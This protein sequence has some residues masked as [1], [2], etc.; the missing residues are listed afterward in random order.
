MALG[1]TFS[2][3]QG[4]VFIIC[5]QLIELHN[6]T[7]SVRT[8]N[9]WGI[10]QECLFPPVQPPPCWERWIGCYLSSYSSEI[11]P[12]RT[13]IQ[14]QWCYLLL[15]VNSPCP[16]SPPTP[17]VNKESVC[18]L[19]EKCIWT[20]VKQNKYCG[21]HHVSCEPVFDLW[22]IMSLLGVLIQGLFAIFL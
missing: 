16:H 2:S 17:T 14:E 1:L 11:L 10:K 18:I 4:L 5:S 3:R 7:E 21:Q 13:D 8:S 19:L 20:A 15:N 6:R 22:E 12:E 9:I